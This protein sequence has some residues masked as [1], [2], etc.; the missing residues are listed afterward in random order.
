[1]PKELVFSLSIDIHLLALWIITVTTTTRLS[2]SCCCCCSLLALFILL[3]THLPHRISHHGPNRLHSLDP[4]LGTEEIK[5]LGSPH[6]QPPPWEAPFLLGGT[7]EDSQQP[8]GD[9]DAQDG[10]VVEQR[11]DDEDVVVVHAALAADG[12]V[13]GFGVPLEGGRSDHSVGVVD[14]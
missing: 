5:P 6:L 14:G 2:R 4:V 12:F 11:A 13:A 8:I 1:M 10:D 7:V 3:P 9:P